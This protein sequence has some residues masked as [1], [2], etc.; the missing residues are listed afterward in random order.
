VLA[1]PYH[2]SDA[3]GCDQLIHHP[4]IV[5][6]GKDEIFCTG[7][8]GRPTGVVAYRAGAFVH[9]LEVGDGLRSRALADALAGFAVATARAKGL[10]SAIF[11]V[12][13][14]NP[15]MQRWVEGI[16]AVKQSEP[17]DLL[18]LLTPP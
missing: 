15:R 14:E 2:F 3:Q 12:R 1:R 17:G 10:H 5:T 4:T 8:P 16:G 18:Y 6:P 13:G 9:E 11:L 7:A